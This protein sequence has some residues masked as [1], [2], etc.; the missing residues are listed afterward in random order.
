MGL[1]WIAPFVIIFALTTA[2][3]SGN[4]TSLQSA[5]ESQ[6]VLRN[7]SAIDLLLKLMDEENPSLSEIE[8]LIGQGVDIN[9]VNQEGLTP[10]LY[11]AR[12]SNEKGNVIDVIQLLFRHGA[13]VTLKDKDG[14]T[15][16]HIVCKFYQHENIIDIIRFL[17]ENGIDVNGKTNELE[18]TALHL[19]CAYYTNENLIDII[20]LF[21]ENGVDIKAKANDG[22]TALHAVCQ[23]Y[24]KQ[25]IME[26]IKLLTNDDSTDFPLVCQSYRKEA[27]IN[28]KTKIQETSVIAEDQKDPP[29]PR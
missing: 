9:T 6:T 17:I 18:F 13:N 4:S 21:I 29:T 1:A 5:T 26:I 25:N 11:I 16:L 3:A 8:N 19:L 28:K 27:E 24:K 23:Y 20:R 12:N 2:I 22:L 14:W 15:A 7:S 10:L